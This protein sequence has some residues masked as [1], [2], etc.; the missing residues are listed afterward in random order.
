MAAKHATQA[1]R[2]AKPTEER[3]QAL[4]LPALLHSLLDEHGR[5]AMHRTTVTSPYND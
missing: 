3:R 4:T 2:R 5:A 1:V